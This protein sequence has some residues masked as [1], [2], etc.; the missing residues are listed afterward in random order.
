MAGSLS[1]RKPILLARLRYVVLFLQGQLLLIRCP[2]CGSLLCTG[3]EP[4]VEVT[5][6]VMTAAEPAADRLVTLYVAY[7]RYVLRDPKRADAEVASWR[8]WVHQTRGSSRS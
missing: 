7:V 2:Y 1:L 5:S 3:L 6:E 4:L 8:A